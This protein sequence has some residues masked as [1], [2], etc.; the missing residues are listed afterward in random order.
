[1]KRA[2][3]VAKNGSRFRRILDWNR[4]PVRRALTVRVEERDGA[5]IIHI[6]GRLTIELSHL[7]ERPLMEA[8][9][10]DA[11]RI[12]VN[13]AACP[14]LDTTGIAIFVANLKRARMAGKEFL[15]AGVG[16]QPASV[17]RVTRLHTVIP[18]ASD[19]D[20]A[21]AWMPLEGTARAAEEYAPIDGGAA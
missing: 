2:N 14:Y 21:L 16:P 10:S 17:L 20:A 6:E 15:L 5:A 8:V 12:V 18:M 3:A 11:P 9:R 19:V 1:M 7:A 13:L 4:Q